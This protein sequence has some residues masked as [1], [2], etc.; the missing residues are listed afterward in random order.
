MKRS[1]ML[2]GIHD[3]WGPLKRAM[4]AHFLQ[5]FGEQGI[6][7]V[8]FELLKTIG[9]NQPLSHKE[10]SRKMQLTPG[11]ISQLLEALEEAKLIVR[12]PSPED[13]RIVLVSLSKPGHDQLELFHARRKQ[14]LDG[15]FAQLDDDELATYLQVQQSLLKYLEAHQTTDKQED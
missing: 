12:T 8:Q 2:Q 6:S 9:C 1:E 15:A 5:Y 11:A 10:L 3:S 14:I 4:H 13:R 7:P